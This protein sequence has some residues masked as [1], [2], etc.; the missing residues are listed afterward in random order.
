MLAYDRNRGAHHLLYEDGEDEW[1]K[2]PAEAVAWHRGLSSAPLRSGL[3]PG[4]APA[5]CGGCGG[6]APPQDML[7]NV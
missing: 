1:I 7:R 4:A 2:L 6:Q 5:A 3:A